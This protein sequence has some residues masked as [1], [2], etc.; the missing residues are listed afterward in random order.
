MINIH[1]SCLQ[2][3][4]AFIRLKTTTWRAPTESGSEAPDLLKKQGIRNDAAYYL[5]GGDRNRNMAR[6]QMGLQVATKGS[7]M[8]K[9]TRIKWE[10]SRY[11]PVK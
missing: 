2:T 1:L 10:K 4:P 11:R 6:I 5:G 7:V 8:G 3:T 9:N